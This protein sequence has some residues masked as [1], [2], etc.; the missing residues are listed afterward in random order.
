MVNQAHTKWF[1]SV[2][3]H[4]TAFLMSNP[5]C[6]ELLGPVLSMLEART[7]HYAPLLQLKGKLD[8]MSKQMTSAKSGEAAR[9]NLWQKEALLGNFIF[10]ALLVSNG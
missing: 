7:K 3:Q 10:I 2:F 8:I 1:K 4:H 6:E 9:D 5:H